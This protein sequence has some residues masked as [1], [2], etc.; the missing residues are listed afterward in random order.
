MAVHILTTTDEGG[1]TGAVF[2][3]SVTGVVF[4]PVWDSVEDAQAFLDYI[5][6]DART[7]DLSTWRALFLEETRANACF[8]W[9]S[10]P[11]GPDKPATCPGCGGV[12][13]VF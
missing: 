6:G 13:N 9:L 10:M 1:E 12:C 5:P 11:G 7:L 2:K 3:D 8:E 4:G